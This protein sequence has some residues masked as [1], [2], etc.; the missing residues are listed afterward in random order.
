[1]RVVFF[2]LPNCRVVALLMVPWLVAAC[3][4]ES[5]TLAPT[6]SPAPVVILTPPSRP[7]AVPVGEAW[8]QIWGLQVSGRPEPV[9]TPPLAP[10]E[11]TSIIAALQ[12][13]PVEPKESR[14]AAE[15]RPGAWMATSSPGSG[16]IELRLVQTGVATLQGES[17][18][19]TIHGVGRDTAVGTYR[20]ATSVSVTLA[21]LSEPDATVEGIGSTAAPFLYGTLAGQ[22]AFSDPTGA[23]ST[24]RLLYWTLQPRASPL[25]V[26][27]VHL[28][29]RPAHD[30][31]R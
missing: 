18:V 6:P 13:R 12:V 1:M 8:L 4:R 31:Y 2:G 27:R 28:R 10:A 25:P 21:G 30:R 14:S 17:L 15:G 24:C 22:F 20:P 19:G 16:T 5:T 3:A 23:T 26:S 11:G 7:I 9:C 29:L